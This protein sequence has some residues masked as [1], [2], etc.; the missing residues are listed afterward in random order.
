VRIPPRAVKPRSGAP[1][2]SGL[3]IIA[4]G[5][6]RSRRASRTFCLVGAG[7]ECVLVPFGTVLGVF[8][9]IMLMKESVKPLFA[10]VAPGAKRGTS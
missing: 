10:A 4:A 5:R 7:L 9:I 1:Q 2:A 6:K 3:Q 8:T